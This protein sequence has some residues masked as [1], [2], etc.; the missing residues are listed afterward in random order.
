MVARAG[1]SHSGPVLHI[2]SHGREQA[3]YI[4]LHTQEQE[5]EFSPYAKK[6]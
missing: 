6:T 2:Y 1:H 3:F 4:P 5:P